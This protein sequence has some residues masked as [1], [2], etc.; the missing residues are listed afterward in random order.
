VQCHD[1]DPG[2]QEKH[3]RNRPPDFPYRINVNCFYPSWQE[4]PG[5]SGYVVETQV[6]EDHYLWTTLEVGGDDAASL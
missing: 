1:S 3:A 2:T 5:I 6:T 4:S